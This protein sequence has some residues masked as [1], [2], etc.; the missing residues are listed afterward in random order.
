MNVCNRGMFDALEKR[1]SQ[2]VLLLSFAYFALLAISVLFS[3]LLVY[4][5]MT[6]QRRWR[7]WLN[8][9]LIDRWLAKGSL[10]S[11]QFR[12]RRP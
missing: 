11:A 9:H 2:T 12:R 3:V 8:E 5:R 7:A 6:A 10:L 4:A 1:D